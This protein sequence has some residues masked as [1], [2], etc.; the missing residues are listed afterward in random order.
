M[1]KYLVKPIS[2]YTFFK[3][4]TDLNNQEVIEAN[5]DLSSEIDN[6]FINLSKEVDSRLCE[7]LKIVLNSARRIQ[8]LYSLTGVTEGKINLYTSKMMAFEI[9]TNLKLDNLIHTYQEQALCSI[10]YKSLYLADLLG[11]NKYDT[12]LRPF[13]L[14]PSQEL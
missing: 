13:T 14:L 9:I 4:S 10:M 3:N 5:S 2:D 11:T 7:E 12:E 6:V 1:E 8:N